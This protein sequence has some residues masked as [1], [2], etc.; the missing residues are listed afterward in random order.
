MK[1]CIISVLLAA[2]LFAQKQND[3]SH[4]KNLAG[5]YKAYDILE[6]AKLKSILKKMLGK[7][8]NHLVTN[9]DVMGPVD[10]IGGNIVLQGNAS[11]K[12]N[13]E[14]ALLDINLYSGVVCAAIY[15][16][17]KIEIFTDKQNYSK[18]D[19]NNYMNVPISI[20]DWLA[21]IGSNLKYRME[22]PGNVTF[23]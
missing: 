1:I 3:F 19:N 11:H 15:S 2:S 18:S 5:D 20:K 9:L 22:K 4:F 12:G 14:M 17:G 6:D 16:K 23:K 13:E 7:E 8:F 10:L 21:V